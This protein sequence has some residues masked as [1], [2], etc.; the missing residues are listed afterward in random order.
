MVTSDKMILIRRLGNDP[1]EVRRTVLDHLAGIVERVPT[2]LKLPVMAA[3]LQAVVQIF[4][5]HPLARA[6]GGAKPIGCKKPLTCLRPHNRGPP[7]SA[8]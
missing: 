5:I 4:S 1:Y 2:F 3:V 7:T 8:A 6:Y